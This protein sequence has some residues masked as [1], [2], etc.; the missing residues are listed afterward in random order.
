M[1]VTSEERRR[2]EEFVGI[3]ALE[4]V[5]KLAAATL[6]IEVSASSENRHLL[7]ALSQ[8]VDS[9]LV[10][11]HLPERERPQDDRPLLKKKSDF[12]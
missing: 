7:N 11:S 3:L 9:L 1:S 4:T 12:L 6:R 5:A 10:A 2:E 8:L